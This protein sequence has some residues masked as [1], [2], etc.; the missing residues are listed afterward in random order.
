METTLYI[1]PLGLA[2]QF[3]A[4]AGFAAAVIFAHGTSSGRTS[5]RNVRVAARLRDAGFAT[6]LMDLQTEEEKADP[7]NQFDVHRQSERL[8]L[9]V[10][11]LRATDRKSVV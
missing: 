11:H 2:G 1:P 6:L 7:A 5:P 8:L 9:A 10:R 3:G 4:P